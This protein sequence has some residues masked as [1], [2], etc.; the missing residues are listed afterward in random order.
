MTKR[1]ELSPEVQADIDRITRGEK[2][3]HQVGNLEDSLPQPQGVEVTLVDKNG[4]QWKIGK[5][6]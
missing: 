2:P 3:K 1:I 4:G 6:L 5:K